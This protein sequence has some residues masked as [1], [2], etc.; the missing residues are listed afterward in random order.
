MTASLDHEGLTE[1][2]VAQQTTIDGL[3][4][5]L[6]SAML[7]GGLDKAE[8]D[9]RIAAL[10]QEQRHIDAADTDAWKTD[11]PA[12]KSPASKTGLLT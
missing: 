7:A 9:R 2:L 3:T 6:A 8:L 4:R 5:T 10:E 11:S 1:V 12:S